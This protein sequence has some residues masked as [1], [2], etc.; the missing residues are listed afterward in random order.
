MSYRSIL[1]YVDSENSSQERLATAFGLAHQLDAHLKVITFGY[2]PSFPIYAYGEPAAGLTA[3]FFAQAKSDAEKNLAIAKEAISGAGVLGDATPEIC[4]YAAIAARFG[5]H[6]RFSDL[7][8]VSRPYGDD[9]DKARADMFEGAL[10]HGDATVLVCP[11][12]TEKVDAVTVIIAWNGSDEALRA[13]RR[14]LP[15]LKMAKTVEIISIESMTTEPDSGEQLALMLSRHGVSCNIVLQPQSLDAVSSVLQRRAVEMGAGLIVMGGYGHSRFRE[16]LI[17][18][19]TRD[20]LSSNEV[21][22]LL[23]H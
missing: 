3:E 5:E 7:V 1:T 8:V 23:S 19:V 21:P 17:G 9:I 2:E 11:P 10:L 6:A 15:F 4:Q 22:V 20:M 12:G 18:G 16:N 14:A 13:T